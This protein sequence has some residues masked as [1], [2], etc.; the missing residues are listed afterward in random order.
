MV[1]FAISFRRYGSL[2]HIVLT[3]PQYHCFNQD[4]DMVLDSIILFMLLRKM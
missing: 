2:F 3:S 1:D 4:M